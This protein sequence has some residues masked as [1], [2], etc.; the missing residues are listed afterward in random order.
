MW[1]ICYGELYFITVSPRLTLKTCHKPR[2]T[3]DTC[4]YQEFTFYP[5]LS[6]CSIDE[7]RERIA[8]GCACEIKENKIFPSQS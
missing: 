3:L 2:A 6:Q 7:I 5:S 4:K 1:L 8:D